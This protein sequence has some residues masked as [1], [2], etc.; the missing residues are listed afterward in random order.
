M[1]SH[2]TLAR[3][4]T[5]TAEENAL[6]YLRNACS[7]SKQAL[8]RSVRWKW[9]V[10]ALHGA[11]YGFAVCASYGTNYQSVLK[12]DG[13][14]ISFWD[15]LKMSGLVLLPSEED[16]I[17]RLTKV[18]RNPFEHFIPMSWTVEIHGMPRIAANVLAVAQKLAGLGQTPRRLGPQTMRGIDLLVRRTTRRL[19]GSR[20]HHESAPGSGSP[21]R[22]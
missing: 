2:A 1:A 19:L 16:S 20:L 5:F 18:L 12:D 21:N 11:V 14:L 6:D 10:I 9:C 3:T 13:K 17:R 7:L 4:V 8:F 22:T 15:A